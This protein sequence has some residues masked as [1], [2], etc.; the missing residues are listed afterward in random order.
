M[1]TTLSS[2]AGCARL[3][4]WS[5]HSFSDRSLP[6]L[7]LKVVV[8]DYLPRLVKFSALIAV[9]LGAVALAVT[10]ILAVLVIGLSG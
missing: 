4:G 6:P 7:G 2:Y 5:D 3:R 8:E 10:G 9:R 1:A